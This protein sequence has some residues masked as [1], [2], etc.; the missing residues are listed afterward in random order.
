MGSQNTAVLLEVCV[1][2]EASLDAA[3]VGG[4]DRIELCSALDLGGLSPSPGFMRDAAAAAPIPV[5]ALI[6]PRAGDFVFSARE[7]ASMIADI[8]FARDVGLNG[9]VLG[10][11]LKDGRLDTGALAEMVAA[12]EGLDLTLHRAFD[13][14]PDFAEA[15]EQAIALG[16]RRILTSG[17]APGAPLGLTVLRDVSTRAGGRISIM[18]GSGISADNAAEFLAL[19]GLVELHASC[20]TPVTGLSGKVLELGFASAHASVT[21]R[22]KVA[23]LKAALARG[24]GP[25]QE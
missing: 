14:V 13:L 24:A 6:R 11:S 20:G 23:A 16:F 19:P 10:A 1:D 9:V 3:I 21:D 4:A 8:D 18:P 25:G 12:A 17:G 5:N 15:L 22:E 7:V 2:A